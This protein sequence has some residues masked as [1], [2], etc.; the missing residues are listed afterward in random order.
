MN[1]V[2]KNNSTFTFFFQFKSILNKIDVSAICCFAYEAGIN[3]D[4][5]YLQTINN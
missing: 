4:I 1:K 2:D 5:K 3:A